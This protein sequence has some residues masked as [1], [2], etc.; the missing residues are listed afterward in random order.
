MEKGQMSLI[1]IDPGHGGR[2]PG[3]CCEGLLEK[4]LNLQIGLALKHLLQCDHLSVSLSRGDDAFKS[5]GQRCEMANNSKADLFLSVHCNASEDENARGI[6]VFHF[7]ASP[8]GKKLAQAVYQEL[9]K[10]G[11]QSRGVK[12]ANYFVLKHTRMP[13]C[14]VECGFITNAEE[15]GWLKNH[16]PEIAEALA[17]GIKKFVG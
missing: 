8:S 7:P 13:A 15:A 5:L 10:L 12:E 6:E 14:L 11:R 16:I 4:E 2:D 17:R 9:L 1:I 3:A